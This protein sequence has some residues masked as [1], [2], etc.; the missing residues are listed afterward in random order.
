MELS[1]T[2]FIYQ[3]ELLYSQQE[4]INLEAQGHSG[5]SCKWRRLFPRKHH[6]RTHVHKTSF[7]TTPVVNQ[8]RSNGASQ[9][10][11]QQGFVTSLLLLA[12]LQDFGLVLHPVLAN[13]IRNSV[14]C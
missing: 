10:S 11:F 2:S 6:Q 12:A 4:N 3:Y 7:L 5:G 9:L 13:R 8:R 1:S 14:N